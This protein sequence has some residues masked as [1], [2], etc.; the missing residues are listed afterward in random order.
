MRSKR[1]GFPYMTYREYLHYLD[2]LEVEK[3]KKA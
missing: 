2:N 3:T 1:F